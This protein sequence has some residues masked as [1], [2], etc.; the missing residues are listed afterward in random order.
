MRA[1]VVTNMWPSDAAPQ[2]GIFVRDQV[3]ALQRR[4]DVDV[5]VLAFPPGPRALLRDLRDDPPRHA[6]GARSTSSTRTSGWRRCPRSPP[7]AALSS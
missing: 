3:E 4:G 2:R 6:R 7:A 5:E 1:L